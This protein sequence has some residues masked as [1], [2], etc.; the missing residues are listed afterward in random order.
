MAK[1][2]KEKKKKSAKTPYAQLNQTDV[3]RL[4]AEAFDKM[5]ATLRVPKRGKPSLSAFEHKERIARNSAEE[6]SR[7]DS[8]NEVAV[9]QFSVFPDTVNCVQV[10][11]YIDGSKQEPI[12]VA[13]QNSQADTE[14]DD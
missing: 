12:R 6:E 8:V 7:D 3:S 13:S 11:T 5:Y 14:K 1:K 10:C 2:K 9:V 4:S